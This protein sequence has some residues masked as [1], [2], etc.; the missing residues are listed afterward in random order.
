MS[1]GP[2]PVC[3]EGEPD[4][5]CNPCGHRFH[6][7]C[8]LDWVRSDAENAET[9]PMCRGRLTGL[10]GTLTL[11]KLRIQVVEAAMGEDELM[12]DG[13][14][15][16]S[17]DSERSGEEDE[18]ERPNDSDYRDGEGAHEGTSDDEEGD[19]EGDEGEGAD[20][21]CGNVGG[22]HIHV[23]DSKLC[24]VCDLQANVDFCAACVGEVNCPSVA[25][26]RCI[27]EKGVAYE[28]FSW[29]CQKC[30]DSYY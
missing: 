21:V 16:G 28:N 17:E 20:D 18:Y 15:L 29:S 14:S 22:D 30:A 2:C 27:L 25:H 19:E 13:E 10:T 24:S 26:L 9:C 12:S 11:D 3:H 1:D 5:T 7:T 4:C 6:T 8:L 23:T